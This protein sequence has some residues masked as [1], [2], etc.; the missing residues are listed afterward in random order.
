[1]ASFFTRDAQRLRS[2]AMSSLLSASLRFLTW[3]SIICISA[4]WSLVLMQMVY[5]LHFCSF[6][7]FFLVLF[8]NNICIFTEIKEGVSW[9]IQAALHRPE[10]N[11]EIHQY[12]FWSI[13]IIVSLHLTKQI[14]FQQFDVCVVPPR[15]NN[16]I[17]YQTA[18]RMRAIKR[19]VIQNRQ[20]YVKVPSVINMTAQILRLESKYFN[21]MMGNKMICSSKG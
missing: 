8:L 16:C 1:M 10:A 20:I 9:Q 19:A 5:H 13:S 12:W 21:H 3:I 15:I 6:S 4:A 17:I 2:A 11:L 7:V 18:G 14:W